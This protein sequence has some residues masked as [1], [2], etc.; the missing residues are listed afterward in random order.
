MQAS[1][2]GSLPSPTEKESTVMYVVTGATGNTGKVVATELLR[3]GNPVRALVRSAAKAAELAK[4]GAEVV[5]LDFFDGTAFERALAGA[6]GLYLLSPPDRNAQDFLT[7]RARVLEA[8]AAAIAR[9]AVPHVVFLSSIGAHQPSGTGVIRT[10]TSG[11]RALWSGGVPMTSVRAAYFVENWG[12]V[13]PAAKKDGVLPSFIPG[14]LVTP[15]VSTS[16]IGV[17]AAEAL[18]DGPRGERI[19]ELAGPEDLTPREIAAHVSTIV[20][21]SVQLLELPLDAVVPTFTSFGISSDISTLYREMYE[22][23]RSGHVSFEA[24]RAELRRGKTNPEVTLRQLAG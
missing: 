9:A 7:E 1:V 3:A 11:E 18:L 16:D 2:A 20:G 15:M 12:A 14:D 4:L 24:G 19:I 23:I 21:K 17:M 13:L 8:L 22:G 10:L 6:S 5:E